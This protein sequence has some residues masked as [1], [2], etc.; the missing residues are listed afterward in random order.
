MSNLFGDDASAEQIVGIRP[1][2]RDANRATIRVGVEGAGKK[3]R[4][5][6]TLTTRIISDMGL[7]VGQAWTGELARRVE[8]GVGLDKAM[9]AAM[10][11]L[12]RR[13]M[14]GWMLRDKLRQLGHEPAVIDQALERLAGLGLLD[15][16]RFGRAL[17]REVMARKPAGPALL[18]Q[19]L[20]QKGIRGALADR[21]IAE[22]TPDADEQQA[23]ATAFAAKRAA[24]MMSL[25]RAVRERRLYGQLARRGF[26]PDTIRV[27]IEA[28]RQ[29]DG[30]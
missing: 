18:K 22:A 3:P 11:R 9:R 28:V 23:A 26:D 4:V 12:G 10:T 15:D 29:A 14:S 7:H 6:A 30:E 5:V 24:G 21:L 20:F 17:I 19:K 2:Q 8:G 16:E 27:A 1:T 25:D 13:A